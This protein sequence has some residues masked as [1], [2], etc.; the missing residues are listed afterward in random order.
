MP[1]PLEN[2]TIALAEGRQLEELAQMLEKE[3]ARTVRCPM[4][5]ILDTPDD[6]P[7]VAWLE[8]LCNGEFAW[9]ILLTGE[10]LRRLLDCAARHGQHERT[11]T[12][13]GRTRLVVRGPKPIKALK[14]VGLAPALV[15]QPATTDGV[16]AALRA[17]NV[18]GLTVGVQ[19]YSEH[20]PP[21]TEF[22][23]QAGARAVTVQPY[24]YAAASDSERVADLIAQLAAGQ[25]D[26]IV[27]TS[28]PQVDRLFEVAEE[29]GLLEQLR[30]GLGR[31]Q[32]ASVGPVLSESL[33]RHGVQVNV[34]PEQG[35]VMK[36]LV[37]LL[38]RSLALDMD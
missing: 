33:E 21:L 32:V 18:K 15:A 25:L 27:F 8:Q 5:S 22:L 12:G 6:A 7:V 26:A 29:R 24:I 23:Q 30:Q 16:I 17:E 14:D 38:K 9:L 19:L 11:L 1:L 31:T 28:S 10:G 3:G 36:N 4:F 37:Q 20:N 2:R 35:F 34:C 13:L